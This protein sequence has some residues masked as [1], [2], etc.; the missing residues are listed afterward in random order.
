MNPRI[1]IAGN[2][3]RVLLAKVQNPRL[4]GRSSLSTVN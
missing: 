4:T 2:T 3:I 1:E